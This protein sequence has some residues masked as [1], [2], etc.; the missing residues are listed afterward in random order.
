MIK[1]GK[2]EKI[3]LPDLLFRNIRFLQFQVESKKGSKL[4]DLKIQDVLRHG[5]GLRSINEPI[6]KKSKPKPQKPDGPILD[7]GGPIFLRTD[8]IR[9]GF[10]I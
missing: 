8:R 5:K 10:E 6:W 4:E 2:S 7:S 1:F 3:G 9:L